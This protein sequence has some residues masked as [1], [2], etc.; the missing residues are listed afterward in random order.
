MRRFMFV[1][2]MSAVLLSGCVMVPGRPVGVWVPGY[3][4][5]GHVWVGGHYRYR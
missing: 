5:V 3:W 4:A 2:L 1:L